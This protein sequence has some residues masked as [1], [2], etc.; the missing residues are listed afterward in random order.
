[1]LVTPKGTLAIN[2]AS[3]LLQ[4]FGSPLWYKAT[5]QVLRSRALQVV[6]E[7]SRRWAGQARAGYRNKLRRYWSCC[8]QHCWPNPQRCHRLTG[9]C[10]DVRACL[11]QSL[12]GC[13]HCA[14]CM[15]ADVHA[16]FGGVVPSLAMEAHKAA[17]DSCVSDALKQAGIQAQ[18]LHAVA[19]SIGPG[20]SP[21]LQVSWPVGH[22]ITLC[23]STRRRHCTPYTFTRS[24]NSCPA[25]IIVSAACLPWEL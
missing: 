1:M 19:V 2:T 8:S 15:Q 23:C 24:C 16:A 20:L 12:A 9:T 17:M 21:C 3:P 4:V 10:R 6:L 25:C 22:S 11:C 18:D 5:A 7:P 14:C 13:L